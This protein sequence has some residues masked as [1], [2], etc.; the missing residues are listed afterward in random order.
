LLLLRSRWGCCLRGLTARFSLRARDG[1][2]GVRLTNVARER[3]V[4]LTNVALK[5]RVRPTNV[6]RKKGVALANA[7]GGT[8]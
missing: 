2:S 8:I 4:R 1:I 5:K 7:D 6:A 3:S